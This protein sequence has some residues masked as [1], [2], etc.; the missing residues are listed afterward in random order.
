MRA[1]LMIILLSILIL[2]VNAQWQESLKEV[3]IGEMGFSLMLPESWSVVPDEEGFKGFSGVDDKILCCPVLIEDDAVTLSIFVYATI[4]D[5]FQKTIM[6]MGRASADVESDVLELGKDIDRP[7]FDTDG[8]EYPALRNLHLIN[9]L[10]LAYGVIFHKDGVRYEIY[11][12]PFKSVEFG[13]HFARFEE[14]LGTIR[15]VG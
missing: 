12:S 10:D 4:R 15:F 3:T 14:V 11:Y 1:A 8:N 6:D 9:K 7:I 13:N 2:P 5:D